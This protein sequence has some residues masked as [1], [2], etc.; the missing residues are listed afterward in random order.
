LRKRT[1]SKKKYRPSNPE[2]IVPTPKKPAPTPDIG[3]FKFSINCK[4]KNKKQKLLFD[5]IMDN[6][7]TFVRGP[8]GTAKAQSLDSKVLT[9]EGWVLMGDIRVG[10]QVM[11]PQNTITTVTGVFPQ[12]IKDIYKI[13]FSDD[14]FTECCDEHLW[15]VRNEQGR[16]KR[17]K[18]RKFKIL[19]LKEI[20]NKINI[21]GRLNFDIPITDPIEFKSKNLKIDP[22]LM[23][24]LLGDGCLRNA[25]GFSTNDEEIYNYIKD[26]VNKYSC[27]ITDNVG[28]NN[29]KYFNIVSNNNDRIN[30]ILN[31]IKEYEL[32]NTLSDTKFVP[33]DYLYSSVQDRKDLLAGLLDT[34]GTINKG[35]ITFCTTSESL[36]NNVTEIVNSLGGVV[37]T[38]SRIGKYTK[39]GISKECKRYYLLH[40]ALNFNPFKLKR[41]RFLYTPRTKYKPARFIKS[42]EFVGKKEAQCIS[43]EDDNHLYITDNYIVTHNTFISLV[44]ALALLKMPKYNI[45]KIVLVKPIVEI[46]SNKGLGALPGELNEKID[47]YFD[48]FYENLSKLVSQETIKFLKDG[49]YISDVVLNYMRGATFG[50]YD[51]DG[52]PIGQVVIMDEAQNMTASE[53]KTFISRMGENSKLVIIGDPDQIDLKLM[54]GEMCG[55]N[56]AINRLSDLESISLVEF[57]E[58]EIVRDPFLIEIMKRYKNK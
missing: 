43:V 36:K 40:I 8:A 35:S 31:F 21:R 4:F 52:N 20:K 18:S 19:Q 9:P 32:F 54:W 27:K 42:I 30:N 45:N 3:N 10:D 28:K 16:N 58:D 53:M 15:A 56:D 55:L 24:L 48:H 26:T 14:S 33:K 2:I 49:K 34:D 44:A 7:I 12:G 17:V 29:T 46:T 51:A 11:T 1:S 50:R 41:K 57:D 38:K 25:I 47:P 22:Y 13:T 39:N 5:S 37:K 6:R 23:G